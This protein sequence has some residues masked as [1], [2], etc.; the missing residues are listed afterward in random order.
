LDDH[1][2][3][4]PKSRVDLPLAHVHRVDAPRAAAKD[5]VGESAGRSV[6]VDDDQPPDVEPEIVESG[7]EL[8]SGA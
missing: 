7:I 2:L 1:A 4:A 8:V 6:Y 3:V 5:A